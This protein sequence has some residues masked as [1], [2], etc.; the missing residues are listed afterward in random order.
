MKK[1]LT[2]GA[3]LL[4]CSF[5]AVA[6]SQ[7]TPDQIDLSSTPCWCQ[8]YNRISQQTSNDNATGTVANPDS[9][10]SSMASPT[11]D[12]QFTARNNR[13]RDDSVLSVEERGAYSQEVHQITR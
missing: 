7:A 10:P 11:G 6:Q 4:A 1:I 12:T 2:I 13:G 8:Q 9:M 3:L 5:F